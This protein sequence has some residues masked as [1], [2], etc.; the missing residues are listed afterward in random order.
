M[1]NRNLAD[2]RWRHATSFLANDISAYMTQRHMTTEHISTQIGC[3]ENVIRGLLYG[4]PNCSIKAAERIE[5]KIGIDLSMAISQ[6]EANPILFNSSQTSGFVYKVVGCDEMGMYRLNAKDSLKDIVSGI[7]AD[8][9]LEY[10]GSRNDI[11]EQN[12]NMV[13]SRMDE[14]LQYAMLLRIGYIPNNSSTMVSSTCELLAENNPLGVRNP[15][16]FY[17]TKLKA[18]LFASFAGMTASEEW[19][20][21]KLLTGGYIDVDRDG[22]MLYYRAMSDDVFENYLFQHT[23]FDRPDRGELKEVA[24]REGMTM[25]SEN[26]HLT[27]KE[28]AE[29]IGGCHGKKGDFGYVYQDGDDFFITI[30]FQVRFR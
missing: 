1:M 30:N 12:I 23:Y 20:G 10:T 2:F 19:N 27:D 16:A 14:I 4:K 17:T 25:I 24:V 7:R 26:R 11:F 13:D 15:K 28:K 3:D 22:D 21:R 6:M 8:Y 9:S 5:N 18:F 29:I